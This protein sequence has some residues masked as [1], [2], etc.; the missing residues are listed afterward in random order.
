MAKPPAAVE[1]VMEAVTALL[2]GRVVSFAETRKLLGGGEAFLTLLRGFR[3]EDLS[4]A[5]LQLVEPYVD[6]PVFR[7]E[8]GSY[9]SANFG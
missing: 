8:V 7:P 6:S 4:D 2:T 1:I 5:R 9:D 3:L